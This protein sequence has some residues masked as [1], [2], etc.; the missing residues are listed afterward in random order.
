MMNSAADKKKI[1]SFSFC[2]YIFGSFLSWTALTTVCA[3]F[4]VIFCV[5]LGFIPESPA[6]LIS[7]G[8]LKKSE[9]VLMR[10][11]GTSEVEDIRK[12]IDG[13]SSEK[14]CTAISGQAP[15]CVVLL[16]V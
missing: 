8:R 3:I 14:T 2:R 1:T 9:Q 4:P 7:N 10:L 13:V 11:R 16:P 15:L 6:H 12:E 5:L